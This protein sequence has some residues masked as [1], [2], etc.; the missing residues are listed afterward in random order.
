MRVLVVTPAGLGHIHPMVPLARALVTRGHE[1]RWAVPEQGAAHVARRSL[2]VIPI[3][4]EP[5]SPADVIR[6]YPEL[7]GLSPRD[8]P[9]AMFGKL[10]GALATPPMLAGLEPVAREW[11]PDLIVA[12]A[13]DFAGH[14]VAAT[15]GI[16]SVT[17]GFG[18]LLPEVR[19]ARAGEEVA[20]LWVE[21]GLEPRPYGGS[22]DSLYIDIYPPEMQ[23]EAGA[24]VR[25]R[26]PM[27]PV[28]D[29]VD[30]N[31]DALPFPIARPDAPL[32]YV[33][34]GTVFNDPDPLR[35]AVEGVSSLPVRVLATVGPS[36]D[37][38]VLGDQ[39]DHV[40]IERYVPQTRVLPHCRV[41]VSHGGSGTV[42]GALAVGL[43]QVCLPQGADQFQNARQWRPRELVSP[44]HRTPPPLPRSGPRSRPCWAT[45]TAR[46]PS[47]SPRRSPRCRH[48]MTSRQSWKSSPLSISDQLQ[49]PRIQSSSPARSKNVHKNATRVAPP[50][51]RCA[52]VTHSAFGPKIQ[53]RTRKGEPRRDEVRKP[54]HRDQSS[55][56]SGGFVA[57]RSGMEW[58]GDE[59]AAP[60]AG[61]V[62][63]IA[64]AAVIAVGCGGSSRVV[65]EAA[66][67]RSMLLR[68]GI[69]LAAPVGAGHGCV[70]MMPRASNSGADR[71]FGSFSLIIAREDSCNDEQAVGDADDAHI[72]WSQRGG[73]WVAH[74]QLEDNLWL[75]M[76]TSERELGEQ[77]HAL[78]TAAYHAF[79]THT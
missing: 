33:T 11:R 9:A 24:H 76:R 10:F 53:S 75:V 51:A 47:S 40:R 71:H 74:E 14:I 23:L 42:L 39:P 22:Y 41:V 38:A 73:G 45:N 37:P 7:A 5:V 3:A 46:L 25:H 35:R 68:H 34:M 77:Q 60:H 56:G 44:L 62:V 20:P 69:D 6:R 32:V 49:R 66:E 17:K 52:H 78:Q 64:T 70:A 43:P 57:Q 4:G 2:E 15:L 59:G 61:R 63:G 36:A 1:V 13:G 8:R 26:Q 19:V 28:A 31:D 65:P 12:D 58:D 21:R 27:R 18:A 30:A 16:R 72:Y 67:V 55:M 48:P 50:N 29:D 79:D 54:A